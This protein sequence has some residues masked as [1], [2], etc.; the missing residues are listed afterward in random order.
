VSKPKLEWRWSDE[1]ALMI[2][3]LADRWMYS[4]RFFTYPEGSYYLAYDD[5]G[6][7]LL[8]QHVGSGVETIEAA[9]AACQRH[10]EE[11]Q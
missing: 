11:Q 7:L 6:V 1:W 8:N 10:W 4:V 3:Y 5:A 2:G 9:K